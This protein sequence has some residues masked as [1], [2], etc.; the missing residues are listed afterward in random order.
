MQFWNWGMAVWGVIAVVELCLALS[1]SVWY[2]R[3]GVP[4]F[5][6]GRT[7][8]LRLS[9][10]PAPESFISRLSGDL[11]SIQFKTLSPRELAFAGEPYAYKY[12]GPMVMHGLIR[13]GPTGESIAVR[14]LLNWYA[15]GALLPLSVLVSGSGV[16]AVV[17]LDLLYSGMLTLVYLTQMALYKNLAAVIV[18]QGPKAEE[19][20]AAVHRG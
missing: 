10:L 14:G 2:C 15:P 6:H 11:R 12:L 13:L 4:I 20:F 8:P 18:E 9:A 5:A 16:L 7:L 3:Y 17:G 1:W 19:G